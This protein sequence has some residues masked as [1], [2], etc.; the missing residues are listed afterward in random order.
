MGHRLLSVLEM[1]GRI[2]LLIIQG[3][4]LIGLCSWLSGTRRSVS[5]PTSTVS[6]SNS[7]GQAGVV[8]R[9]VIRARVVL[10]G[11]VLTVQQVVMSPLSSTSRL[12]RRYI[13][14]L[15]PVVAEEMV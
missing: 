8:A 6:R 12:G 15:V 2:T 1:A 13:R 9:V 14:G 5:Q 11:R 10:V 7:M 3:L 4:S